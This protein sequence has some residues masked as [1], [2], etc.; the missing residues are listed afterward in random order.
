[1]TDHKL[2]QDLFEVYLSG[3]ASEETKK[4]VEEH[5]AECAACQKAFKQ[6]QA[7]EEALRS[8]EKVEKPTNGKRYVVSLRR[9]L[10]GVGA[11]FLALLT[12]LLAI[13]EYIAFNDILGIQ[14]PRLYIEMRGEA[15]GGGSLLAVAAYITSLWLQKKQKGVPWLWTFLRVTS[16]IFLGFAATAG[17]STLRHGEPIFIAVL[18]LAIYIYLLDWRKKLTPGSNRVEFFH[19]LEAVIPLFV[20]GIGLGSAEGLNT[21]IVLSV[22]LIVALSITMIQLPK[23]RYMSMATTLVMLATVGVVAGQTCYVILNTLDVF[24]VVPSAL[25]HP[26]AGAD[27]NGYVDYSDN[28]LEMVLQST[29][30]V[31]ELNGVKIEDAMQARQGHYLVGKS[32]GRNDMVTRITVIEFNNVKAAREFI[33]AWFPCKPYA[34]YCDHVIDLDMEDTLLFEGR[35]LRIYDNDTAL[36]HNAWQT[37]NWVTII[38]TE[39]AFVDAMPL[40][41]E[42][43]EMI[44]DRYRHGVENKDSGN[45]WE[46]L[47]I[48]TPRVIQ[49]EPTVVE[50]FTSIPWATE[51]ATATLGVINGTATPT[52]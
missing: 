26:P 15:A 24:P 21:I 22:L 11:G 12:I 37:L 28:Q 32:E 51:T 41:K 17:I 3:E 34:V 46:I 52:P 14:V 50:Y 36:A 9:V 31:D 27:L 7:A 30:A 16:M 38:E 20:L 43:R 40:N 44:A 18:M 23:L 19:S 35:F 25:G 42:I 10:Y 4:A 45:D 2:I 49:L 13:L 29:N 8:L 39:G 33:D 47:P 48:E 5:L 6:A 1:M